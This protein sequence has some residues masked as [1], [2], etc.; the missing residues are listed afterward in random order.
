MPLANTDFNFPRREVFSPIWK[1]LHDD[2]RWLEYRRAQGLSPERVD[3]IKFDP[4]L[5]E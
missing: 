1:E 2:P 4:R 3:A 5:P